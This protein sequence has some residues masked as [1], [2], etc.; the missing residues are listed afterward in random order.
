MIETRNSNRSA[1]LLEITKGKTH[2]RKQ[3]LLNLI[4]YFGR[5]VDANLD[6]IYEKGVNA[7]ERQR[8]QIKELYVDFTD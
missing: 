5:L 8:I 6:K 7:G 1:G 3:C 2:I 4:V